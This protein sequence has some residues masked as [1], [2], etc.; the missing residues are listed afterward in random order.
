MTD[1]PKISVLLGRG[2]QDKTA[3]LLRRA[4]AEWDDHLKILA[5]EAKR[6]KAA[7]DAY[8][9]AGFTPEQAITLVK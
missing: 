7:Y 2:Q 5:F 1:T 6:K 4:N 8:I 9:Q 3:D